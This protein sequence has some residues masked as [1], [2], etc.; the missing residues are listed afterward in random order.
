MLHGKIIL[1]D[2]LK[3]YIK[4]TLVREVENIVCGLVSVPFLLHFAE[5]YWFTFPEK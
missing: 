4:K 1:Y 5:K 2:T 3:I